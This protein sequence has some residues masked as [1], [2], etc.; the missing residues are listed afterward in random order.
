LP[1]VEE[2]TS[3][4]GLGF[5]ARG[6]LLTW[7]AIHASAEEGSLAVH[8]DF[9]LR[10]ELLAKTPDV[11][12]VT[13]HYEGYPVVLVRLARISRASLSQLLGTS[14]LFVTSTAPKRRATAGAKKKRA[15][16]RR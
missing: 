6:K 4:R 8:V 10:A 12:Y 2:V 9:N 15:R 3:S 13:P 16:E 7:P 14:W 5:T 1:D 11:Y